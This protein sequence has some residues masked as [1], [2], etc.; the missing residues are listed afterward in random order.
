MPVAVSAKRR[1]A[2][3]ARVVAP[4]WFWRRKYRILQRLGQSNPEIALVRS[5]CDPNRVSLDVGAAVGEFT[6]A[7]LE[8]SRSV[9]AFEPRPTQAHELAAMF[10]AVGAAVRVEPVALSD[11]PGAAEMRELEL[12]PGRSTIDSANALTDLEG[13]PVRIVDVRVTRLDDLGLDNVGF[14]KI[15]VEGH[16]FAVLRGAA[17]TLRRNRPTLFIEAEERHHPGAVAAIT[18]FLAGLGYTGYF[19]IDG[20]RRAVDEFNPIEHQDQA[21]IDSRAARGLYV[22]DFVFVPA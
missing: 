2:P 8:R 19:D 21:N 17:D 18:E 6:I 11:K 12:E 5:L 14:I 1:L 20:I 3:L 10:E 9:I 16:E 4:R 22:N 7:M 15:D 13:S